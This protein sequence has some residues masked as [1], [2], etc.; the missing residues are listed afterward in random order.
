MDRFKPPAASARIH[1][2]SPQE[3]G[4]SPHDNAQAAYVGGHGAEPVAPRA[5]GEYLAPGTCVDGLDYNARP[6]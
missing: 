3:W 5:A 4:V 6:R 1:D 2:A